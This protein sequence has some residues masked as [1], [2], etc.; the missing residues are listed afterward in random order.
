MGTAMYQHTIV[1]GVAFASIRNCKSV[2]RDGYKENKR[3]SVFKSWLRF[4]VRD[5]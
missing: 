5:I 4:S 1:W 2:H 3:E